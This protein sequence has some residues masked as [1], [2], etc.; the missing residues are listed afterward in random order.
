MKIK[1]MSLN[2]IANFFSVTISLGIS[3]I[4][5]PYIVQ[6]LGKEAYSFVPISN[7]FTSYMAILTI[8]MT[9]MSGRFITF[10]VHSNDI[11]SAND[12]YSTSFFANLLIAG[13]V[14]IISIFIIFNL[15]KLI[16]IP[17]NIFSDV[18]LLFI[19]MFMSF[20]LNVSTTIFSTSTFCMNRLDISSFV[21]IIGSILRVIVIVIT[22]IFLKPKIYFI[23]LS[24]FI[25]ILIQGV[26]NYNYSK[27]IMPSLKISYRNF[28]KKIVKELISSGIWNSFNQLSTILLTGLDLLVANLILGVSASGMLAIAKTAPMALQSLITVVP[29]TFSPYLTILFAKGNKKDFIDKLQLILKFSAL[30]TGIPIA[31]FIVLSPYFFQLWIP[32]IAGTEI[33]TLAILTMISMIASFS[34]MPLIYVFTITNRLKW[35]SISIFFSGIL[36]L[37]IVFILIKSTNLGLYAIAGVSSILEIFRCLVFIP[38]YSAHCL[39]EKK[40]VFF[41]TIKISMI[42][43]G[44]LSL[45]YFL[46]T[47]IISTS[48]WLFILFSALVM[49]ILGIIIGFILIFNSGEKKL[50]ILYIIKNFENHFKKE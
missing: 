40:S 11:K 21:S 33:T 20:V 18:K 10:K 36:S 41:P 28:Q 1:Q 23:G 47:T 17:K 35:L 12:Y 6:S 31:G 3:F 9:S 48:S 46:I 25:V 22:F 42:Y 15:D 7:N 38:V 24:A 49:G 45:V 32:T 14:S 50:I 43:I 44:I 27:K 37:I 19:I 34:V 5:T 13:I 2:I 4:L 39:N 26:L 30:L 8:A 29:S 16:N